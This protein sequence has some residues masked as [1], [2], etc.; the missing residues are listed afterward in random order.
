V[1]DVSNRLAASQVFLDRLLASSD[2]VMAKVN[3]GHGSLGLLVN[4]PSLYHRSDSLVAE[5]HALVADIRAHP[6]RYV[7]VRIF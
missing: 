1:R 4:N 5:M 7:N 6:G 2:S 3:A